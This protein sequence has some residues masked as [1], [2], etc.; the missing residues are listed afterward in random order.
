MDFR[1]TSSPPTATPPNSAGNDGTCTT[2]PSPGTFQESSTRKRG[3]MTENQ[4][5]SG[6]GDEESENDDDGNERRRKK[7]AKD[8]NLEKQP[9]PRLKCPF[10]Q[11]EPEKYSRA[12]CRGQGFADM[13]KLK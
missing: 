10:F 5:Q 6:N 2:S 7:Q 12:A 8:Y 9:K 3:R 13:A 4:H 11:R 1:H